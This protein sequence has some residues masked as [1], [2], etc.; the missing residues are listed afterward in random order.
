MIVPRSEDIPQEVLL[1]F[2]RDATAAL[3]RCSIGSPR[4]F[5]D[6]R[7]VVLNE[8]RLCLEEIVKEYNKLESASPLTIDQVQL[9]LKN[10]SSSN[11][12][13]DNI[14]RIAMDGMNDSA[15]LC[16]TR[17]VLQSECLRSV[18]GITVAEGLKRS[19]S[20]NRNDILE[21]CGLCTVALRFPN[22][23]SHVQ[24]GTP[25]F[26]GDI[27]EDNEDARSNVFPDH[28]LHAIQRM[29]L[30]AI[31]YDADH[32]TNEIKRIFF[33]DHEDSEF[34][35]DTELLTVFA[36]MAGTMTATLTN[37]TLQ[38]SNNALSDRDDGGVTRVVSVSYSEK[39]IDELSG[40]ELPL[41]DDTTNSNLTN[42]APET[43]RM[44]GIQLDC[45]DKLDE[46]RLAREA[47]RLQQELLGELLIMRDEDREVM[48][49]LAKAEAGKF[50]Q[51]ALQIPPGP[52]RIEY[53]QSMDAQTQKLLAMHKLWEG[54]LA[55]NEG[56]A[57][58]L[59]YSGP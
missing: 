25:L 5:S 32:G 27:N 46:L 34:K 4:T 13:L 23:Q 57:P 21:F 30:Q 55:S 17:L 26:D 40:R 1:K 14:V 3:E 52:E 8:Q 33:S 9:S 24:N 54:M 49:D 37:A 47:S 2:F 48:L 50:I 11:A 39:L 29:F 15:R 53:M 7:M 59:R 16:F 38:A 43:Q 36:N 51:T 31:G 28:R 6:L 44:Q 56:K 35:D 45:E 12:P 58:T 10:L 41:V 20:L 42:A 19:E 18:N 22:V